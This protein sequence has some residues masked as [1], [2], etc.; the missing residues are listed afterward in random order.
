MPIP[1]RDRAHPLRRGA[2]RIWPRTS[3]PRSSSTRRCRWPRSRAPRRCASSSS[4]APCAPCPARRGPAR[5]SRRR[6]PPST[7]RRACWRC[8]SSSRP[9]A[10]RPRPSTPPGAATRARSRARRSSACPPSPTR[11]RSS[12][13]SGWRARASASARGALAE[14]QREV[15]DLR[16][17]DERHTRWLDALA[18]LA[19]EFRRE[20][21]RV[22]VDNGL[23]VVL[24][25]TN[26]LDGAV[27]FY[28]S[29][30]LVM[31][32]SRRG[33]LESNPVTVSAHPELARCL[34]DAEPAWLDAAA[35]SAA[36]RAARPA[37]LGH[38]D[39]RRRR[40]AG[41]ARLRLRR[42]R[43]PRRG[44]PPPAARRSRPPWASR[45]CATA[46]PRSCA[47][48]PARRARTP[49]TGTP[50]R[51]AVV[52]SCVPPAHLRRRLGPPSHVPP[53]AG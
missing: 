38:P 32:S 16:R 19:E 11:A 30:Q 51:W 17:R 50:R 49:R 27:A 21:G 28:V 7:T 48:P 39:R 6:C 3:S 44:Q 5:S 18:L 36:R 23:D 46:W 40:D 15:E 13:W 24:R 20:P 4:T 42:R 8:S 47:R 29:G 53:A 43:A 25:H 12:P 10:A 14:L 33:L 1:R 9:R 31:P 22:A 45:C 37:R 26:A 41:P 34:R 52:R 35:S 2:G